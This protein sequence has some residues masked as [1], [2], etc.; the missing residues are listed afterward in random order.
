MLL[1]SVDRMNIGNAT[2]AG[3]E[4]D[5]HLEGTDYNAVLSIFYIP[6]ILFEMPAT[7]CCKVLGPGWFLPS[8]ALGFGIV[9][10]CTAFFHDFSSASACRFHLGVF[11]ASMMP[12][13]AYYLSR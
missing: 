7:V 5:L 6:Y 10:V 2:L 13:I 4:R 9:S 8:S 12:G 11:E 3:F 1:C